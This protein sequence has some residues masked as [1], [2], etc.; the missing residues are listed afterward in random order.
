MGDIVK[1]DV[2]NFV[3]SSKPFIFGDLF[4]YVITLL[5]TLLLVV[6]FVIIP[7]K[8]QSDGFIVSVD[9][10][11]ILEYSFSSDDVQILDGWNNNVVVEN[12]TNRIKLTVTQKDGRGFNVIEINKLEKTAKIIDSNC[13][14]KD[15]TSIS[16]IKNTGAIPCVAHKLKVTPLGTSSLSQPI[17]G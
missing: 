8:T 11:K 9:G 12:S 16:S 2:Y 17:T 4:V 14:K 13:P 1:K 7:S 5:L 15:C 10:D 6:F 3:K